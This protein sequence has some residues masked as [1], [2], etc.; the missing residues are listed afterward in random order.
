MKVRFFCVALA[1]GC[2]GAASWLGGCGGGGSTASVDAGIDANSADA[3]VLDSSPVDST[4]D[5][6]AD[7]GVDAGPEASTPVNLQIVT[8]NDAAL[9]GSPGDAVPLQVVFL[10]AD[11]G[12]LIV[13]QEQVTWTTPQ[14][15]AAQNPNDPGDNTIPDAGAQPTAFFV[16]NDF[17]M[18]NTG[19]LYLVATGTSDAGVTVTASVSDAG[20]VSA[21]VTVSGTPLVGNATRGGDLFQNVLACASCHGTTA[22]GSP[23]VDAGDAGDAG[24]MYAIPMGGD[25]FP[26]PAPA[27]NAASPDNLAAD[28][29]WNAALLGMAAQSDMDNAG[30][31]LQPPMP[32][33]FGVASGD[34]GAA[35]GAQDFADIYAWLLTQKK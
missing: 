26:Y 20:P 13:P 14:T 9:Q 19:V 18:T 11:G 12:T 23:A 24:P 29:T 4:P 5:T 8:T 16:T 33:F 2:G 3:S 35:L 34:G 7:S 25:L 21:V 32:D 30:V 15:I 1:A 22:G 31:A 28:P 17:R 27:L 10:L 6:M